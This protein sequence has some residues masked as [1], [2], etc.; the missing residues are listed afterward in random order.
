MTEA[1]EE[2]ESELTNMDMF[3]SFEQ[4]AADLSNFT[5]R[6]RKSAARITGQFDSQ[7][8]E[9]EK[10]I[11]A[12]RNALGALRKDA[13]AKV[14]GKG[15][16]LSTLTDDEAKQKLELYEEFARKLREAA[17]G[18]FPLMQKADGL[19]RRCASLTSRSIASSRKPSA[20]RSSQ[21]R[22]TSCIAAT[23]SGLRQSRSGC[24]G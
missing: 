18:T 13:E 21:K 24:S 23:T 14:V 17:R 9:L 12:Q 22:T 7:F 3:R 20:P 10:L 8:D 2:L 19:S 4:E 15:V 16:S 11:E 1:K 6:T 5:T